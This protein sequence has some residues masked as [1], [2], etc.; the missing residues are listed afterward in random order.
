MTATRK[1]LGQSRWTDFY[2]R[3]RCRLD[4]DDGEC[5]VREWHH[6]RASRAA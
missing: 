5:D 3:D 6:R 2:G 4:P 1:P